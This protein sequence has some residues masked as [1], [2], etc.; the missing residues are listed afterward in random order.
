[1]SPRHRSGAD[2]APGPPS[3]RYRISEL[4]ALSGV[5]PATIHHYRRVG[6][7]PSAQVASSNRFLYDDTHL[8][9][10][11]LI[12]L[13]R[14]RRRLPLDVIAEI[15]PGLLSGGEEAF[16]PEMWDTAIGRLEA[17]SS[18]ERPAARLL[19]AAAEAFTRQPYSEVG[20]GDVSTAAGM[21]K[22]TVY[23]HFS[24]KAELFF[25]AAA[26]VVADVLDRYDA[27]TADSG[28]PL[29]AEKAAE[30]L[31]PLFGERL[32]LLLELVTGALQGRAG[33]PARAQAVMGR[34][35]V[36]VG[37]R[38]SGPEDPVE[39]GTKTLVLAAVQAVR[40]VLELE[41]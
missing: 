25:G 31:A 39:R 12:K 30:V 38:V 3:G 22:G 41:G 4:V 7:L 35:A 23:R 15:L 26:A 17:T 37:Q 36:E 24:S 21:A 13:L 28:A 27:Q 29:A 5:P 9:A 11:R 2:K 20:V 40:G 16:R 10:L 6:L 19:A 32:A 34:L 18:P 8:Q 14:Q 1:M 33:Y